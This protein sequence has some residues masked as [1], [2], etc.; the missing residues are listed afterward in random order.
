M[1]TEHEPVF[2]VEWICSCGMLNDFITYTCVQCGKVQNLGYIDPCDDCAL[3]KDK[4]KIND[5]L[6]KY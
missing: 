4:F 5:S 3:C 6:N 1:V 2:P